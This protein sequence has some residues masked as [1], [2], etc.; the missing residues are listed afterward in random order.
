MSIKSLVRNHFPVVVNALRLNARYRAQIYGVHPIG[1]QRS[2]NIWDTIQRAYGYNRSCAENACVDRDGNPV[3]WYTYPA[4]EFLSGLSFAGKDVWE[5]GCGNSTAWWAARARSVH[6]VESDPV[7]YKIVDARQ[8]P[9]SQVEFIDGSDQTAYVGSIHR[10]Q[11]RFDVIVVDGLVAN[12]CRLAC[13][14]EAMTAL[15]PGGI[16]VL[17]NSDRLP[18]SCEALSAAGFTEIPFN[19]F[20]PLNG[21][22]SRTSIFFRGTMDF[23]K[24][25]HLWV[26]GGMTD[27]WE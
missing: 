10:L 17:D 16:I 6:S 13:A 2:V 15:N 27:S 8:I 9:N 5:F 23:Q 14:K 4:I 19:G 20:A 11:R 7:W 18:K 3:P 24:L 22:P 1:F 26:V 12:L 21:E 25:P